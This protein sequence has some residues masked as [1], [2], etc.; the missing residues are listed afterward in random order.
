MRTVGSS[1]EVT[2]PVI[3][4]AG[5]ELLYRHGFEAMN[6]RQLAKAAGLK[7]GGSLYNYFESKED[8]LFRL[9][10]EVMEEILAELEDNVGPVAAPVERVKTFVEFHIKW[11]TGRREETFISHMEMRS[12]APERYDFYVGLRKRYEDFVARMI[13]AGCKSGDFSV[14]DV[15][16]VT[17]SILSMLTSVCYWYRPGGR[18]SPK[19]LIDIHVQM[20]LAILRSGDLPAHE[21]PPAGRGAERRASAADRIDR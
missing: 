5:I 8:F 13:Q 6:L 2:W 19:R 18:I 15:H 11:H 21:Q 3:R 10:C 9:M 7:G 4:R 12:L 14:P 17:Q 1:R 16:V 20:V